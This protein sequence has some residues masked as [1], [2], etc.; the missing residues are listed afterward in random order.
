[1]SGLRS[2]QHDAADF[3]FEHDRSMVL[4]PVGA[5]KTALTLVAMQEYIE[6]GLVQ[7]WLV[8]APKRVC[9][10]VWPQECAL[11]SR[12]SL[13]I[14][15]GTP[16]E[17][18]ATLEGDSD[19]VVINY[20]NIQWLVDRYPELPFQGVVFDE[21]T[22]L[23]N[24]SG[25]RFKA[26]H[27]V[28]D[29]PIRI[30]L[31]GSFTSNGLEDVFGQCK[32]IDQS[33]LGRSKGAFLQQYFLLV[34]RDYGQWAPL[35]GALPRVMQRIKPATY[36]LEPGDYSDQLPPLHTVVLRCDLRNREP[37]EA[38]RRYFVA[39][40]PSAQII[41]ANSGAVTAKLQQMACGFCYQTTVTP[42][43]IPGKMIREQH[44]VWFDSAKFDLLDELLDENQHDNTLVWYWYKEEL[45]ELK[46]RY[47]QAQTLDDP[48][49]VAR[50]N[51]GQIELL[52]AHPQSAGHGMNLQGQNKMVFLSLPWSLELYEQ[53]IGRLLRSGQ[54]RDVWCY[55]LLANKTI[56][57]QIW[58]ALSDK[59][60][61]SDIAI[62]ALKSS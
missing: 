3:I 6:Q 35:A 46:R 36:L 56:D 4:A 25:E 41:A 55:V 60:A 15:V 31:T 7:R 34:N 39:Q 10:H 29:I 2:Y 58:A 11:W 21:L 37:Y 17:R 8:I 47:P 22:R 51:A 54:T 14:A 1:M 43:V 30:G 42:S 49:A 12:L 19:I 5:G 44:P 48:D 32:I 38:M 18:R 16:A 28:L 27:K 24:A 40:F 26:L 61:I 23:K 13:R 57:G 59:R 20:D 45:A 9:Q 52:L 53:A 33:L 50:W 62:A